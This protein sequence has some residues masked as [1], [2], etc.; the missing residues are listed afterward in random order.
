MAENEKIRTQG[1]VAL[2]FAA[3]VERTRKVG[4]IYLASGEK[5]VDV[6]AG[7]SKAPVFDCCSWEFWCDFFGIVFWHHLLPHHLLPE[8]LLFLQ[9]EYPQR[10]TRHCPCSHQSP[11]HSLQG[12]QWLLFLEMP[13]AIHDA[14]DSPV[15]HW[16]QH[17]PLRS[18]FTG[19]VLSMHNVDGVLHVLSPHG[20]CCLS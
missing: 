17:L 7:R 14:T 20:T 10:K 4:R 1:D 19:H 2:A 15:R 9:V 3:D 13:P 11:S 18:G 12:K 6:L 8:A 5:V 16:L